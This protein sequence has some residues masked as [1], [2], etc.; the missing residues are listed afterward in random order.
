M[1]LMITFPRKGFLKIGNLEW[2]VVVFFQKH[3]F[4]FNFKIRL[5]TLRWNVREWLTKPWNRLPNFIPV[6]TF[7]ALYFDFKKVK[8]LCLVERKVFEFGCNSSQWMLSYK[9]SVGETWVEKVE[10]ARRIMHMNYFNFVAFPPIEKRKW[11]INFF[12]SATQ[13]FKVKCCKYFVM[14][15]K[16]AEC[17]FENLYHIL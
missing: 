4:K 1:F 15:Q 10:R 9:F 11:N 13:V 14:N 3:G 7:K 16:I 8:C 6:C 12:V 2:L 17:E 5:T